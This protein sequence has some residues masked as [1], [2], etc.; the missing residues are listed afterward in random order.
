MQGPSLFVTADD[1]GYHSA[2]NHGVIAALRAGYVSHASLMVNLP[3]FEEACDLAHEDGMSARIGTHVNL[4][5][6]TP[7][8]DAMR[9]CPR[10]S[11]DGVFNDPDTRSRFTPLS[12]VEKRAVADEIRA[13]VALVR[14]RGFTSAHLDSHRYVHTMPNMAGVFVGVAREIGVTRIRPYV[15]CRPGMVG[16]KAI[17]KALYRSWL[18]ACGFTQVQYFGSIDDMVALLRTRPRAIA[19]AEIMTH[20]ILSH[21]AVCDG[22]Q[23]PLFDRLRQL[24]ALMGV[25][26]IPCRC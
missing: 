10:F 24:E 12:S 20:P 21:G 18:D 1:F 13:Q 2:A 3:G 15:N 6:G 8:T 26:L 19:S 17:G 22:S 9:A 4:A 25:Q 14:R 5:E 11:S 16:V 23:G 7:L